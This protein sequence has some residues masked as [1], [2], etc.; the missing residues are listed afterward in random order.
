MSQY[1][2]LAYNCDRSMKP[3]QNAANLQGMIDRINQEVT[4]DGWRGVRVVLFYPFQNSICL[5][6]E[7]GVSALTLDYL[8]SVGVI[9]PVVE[10]PSDRLSA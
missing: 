4:A 9:A 1:T 6:V 10:S 2:A 8:R 3:D 7:P 5:Q